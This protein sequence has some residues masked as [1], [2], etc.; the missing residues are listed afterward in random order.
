MMSSHFKKYFLILMSVFSLSCCSVGPDFKQPDAP[1]VQ[2]YT[3]KP[4]VKKTNSANVYAG[5]TQYFVN[6]LDIPEKWWQLFRSHSLNSLIER[7]IHENPTLKSAHAALLVAQENISAQ[8]GYYYPTLQGNYI[9]DRSKTPDPV[10]PLAASNSPYLTLYTAQ[11]TVFY[12]ADVFGLNRRTVESLRAQAQQLRFL[13]EATYL[14]LTSN[15]VVAAIQ[16]ASLR[17]QI[18]ATYQLI[19]INTH[20]LNL[21]RRKLTMGASN[22]LDVAAQ[23]AQ[24]AQIKATLPPLLKQL[25]IQRDLL[26]ALAGKFPSQEVTEKFELSSLQLP[27]FLPVSL[28]AKLIRQRPDILQAE[29]NLHAASANIGVARANRFPTIA[30]NGSL[31][32]SALTMGTLFASGNG[33]W[34]IGGNLLQPIFT[35]GTLL[36]RE[37]AAK[38]AYVQAMEQYRSTVITAFQNVADTLHALE[39][40]ANALQSAVEAE[41]ATKTTLNLT[42][43]QMKIGYVNLFAV[44][45]AEQAYQQALINRIQTQATRFTDTVALFQALGGGW[46]NKTEYEPQRKY[47]L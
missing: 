12:V 20:L 1:N 10:S 6:D 47:H 4:L 28:P 27:S 29:E 14:T 18:S 25:A 3:A 15:V 26:T 45:N 43:R 23:E 31:G 32:S 42:R 33:L 24:L 30:I 17:T 37:R 5:Q 36:H 46:W 21:F 7:S 40:D 2:R 34:D 9:P 8:K 38:M 16:E 39:Q 35:G 44:L 11:L 19:D 22:R 41:R 13:L